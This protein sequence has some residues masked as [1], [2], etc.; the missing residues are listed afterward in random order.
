[1]VRELNW[2]LFA[3]MVASFIVIV[4]LSLYNRL[5][6][7]VAFPHWTYFAIMEN[8]HEDEWKTQTR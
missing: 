3:T 6:I 8:A 4:H 7:Y 1:M 5:A 2:F